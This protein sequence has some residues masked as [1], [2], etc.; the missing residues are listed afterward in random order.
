VRQWLVA[1]CQEHPHTPSHALQITLREQFDVLISVG[2]LNQ[3]RAALGVGYVRPT[4]KF[5]NIH[6][7]GGAGVAGGCGEPVTAGCCS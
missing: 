7:S 4:K 1:Y 6:R 3:I 5:G 2:Y